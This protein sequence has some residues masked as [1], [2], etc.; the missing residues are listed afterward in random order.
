M[1]TLENKD[2]RGKAIALYSDCSTYRYALTKMWEDN[3]PSLMFIMLNPSTAT[4][5]VS[6]PT[7]TRCL[8]RSQKLG[9]GSMT[10]CNLFAYRTTQ[11]EALKKYHAPVGPENDRVINHF[12][13]WTDDIVCAWGTWGAHGAHGYHIDVAARLVTLLRAQCKPLHHFGLTEG[14]QPRHPLYI[15]YSKQL[16]IW[17]P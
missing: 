5:R 15:P 11:P 3:K 12:I 17:E 10:I 6:D 2:F 9:Y 1:I 8:V 16:E 14:G 7:A 4:E 13:E